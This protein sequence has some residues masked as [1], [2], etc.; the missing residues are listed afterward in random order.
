[1]TLVQAADAAVYHAKH[2]R[3][4]HQRYQAEM[5]RASDRHELTFSALRQALDLGHLTAYYQPKF[6]V[7]TGR[8]CGVE[9]L[10]RWQ[11]P[12]HGTIEAAD[13]VRLAEDSGL[14]IAVGE[15]VL[16]T[17]M[18]N[19]LPWI[20]ATGTDAFRLAVNISGVHLRQGGLVP[21]L[22]RLTK[23][24]GFPPARL[25]LELTE[26]AAM[27][28]GRS[29]ESTLRA[30]RQ[31]GFVLAIDDFGTGYSS[32]SRLERLPVDVLKIDQAFV[33]GIGQPGRNG[34]IVKAITALGHSLG[35]QVVGE[36]VETEAQL[37]FLREQHCDVAQGFLLGRPAPA[38]EI[39]PI[40]AANHAHA[41][42]GRRD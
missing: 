41:D 25:E 26:S 4:T 40:I 15:Y 38:A 3:N 12:E 34:A 30:L 17:A 22:D 37:A 10:V 19:A 33:A 32:L 24:V 5:I 11:H 2:V 35:L 9:A 18:Q 14:I 42:I 23:D 29:T 1:V 31:R 39:A 8:I 28:T 20:E 21:L 7:A 13:L 6:D 27:G 36:G 16:R